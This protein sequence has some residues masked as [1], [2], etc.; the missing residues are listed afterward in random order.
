[1]ER[2]RNKKLLF[3]LLKASLTLH[4]AIPSS[5]R[6]SWGSSGNSSRITDLVVM[7]GWGEGQRDPQMVRQRPCC[8]E[9][10]GDYPGGVRDPA[11]GSR[12]H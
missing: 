3:S 1:M 8:S 12:V 2:G 9:I 4:G 7:P 6:V 10:V 5:K 11:A